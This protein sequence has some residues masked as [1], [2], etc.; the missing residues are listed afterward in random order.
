MAI[1]KFNISLHIREGWGIVNLA[2]ALRVLRF[3]PGEQ[4][5]SGGLGLGEFRGGGAHRLAGVDRLCDGGG[6]AVGFQFCEGGVENGLGLPSA[7]RSFPAMRALRPGVKASA[8][9]P[10]YW[11]GAIEGAASVRG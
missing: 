1:Q 4:A 2:Q 7:R 6:Q 3:V 8:S 9:H 11:S 5:D 10:R